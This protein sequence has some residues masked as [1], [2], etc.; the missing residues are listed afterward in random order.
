MLSYIATLISAI[1]SFG[2]V[3]VEVYDADRPRR[4]GCSRPTFIWAMFTPWRPGMMPMN[5]ISPGMSRWVKTSSGPV[6]VRV[7]A[8]R[9]ELH[10]P[11]EYLPK[12][13]AA[14]T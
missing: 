1:A 7:R 14:A 12:R 10:E 6:E 2:Q 3:R 5:P 13:V 4:R 9:A 8:D 11:D